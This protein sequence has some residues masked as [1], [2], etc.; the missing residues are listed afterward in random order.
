MQILAIYAVAAK[1]LQLYSAAENGILITMERMCTTVKN[2]FSFVGEFIDSQCQN[3]TVHTRVCG[4]WIDEETRRR[5][6]FI[7]EV[8]GDIPD[9]FFHGCPNLKQVNLLSET[10]KRI[11]KG[12]FAHCPS[13]T[14]LAWLREGLAEIDDGAFTGC[15]ALTFLQEED[16]HTHETPKSLLYIG[17]AAFRGTGLTDIEISANILGAYAFADCKTLETVGLY[18]ELS[19]GAFA[20]AGCTALEDVDVGC[21]VY[22]LPS[23]AFQDCTALAPGALPE[24]RTPDIDFPDPGPIAYEITTEAGRRVLRFPGS[25]ALTNGAFDFIL[26]RKEILEGLTRAMENPFHYRLRE[27]ELWLEVW[28]GICEVDMANYTCPP[29]SAFIRALDLYNAL[30]AWCAK[31]ETGK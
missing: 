30:Q 18:G 10:T 31:N 19:V 20:F 22:Y 23:T 14:T 8:D 26:Y 11:G 24:S 3:K 16:V 13:L 7:R 27:Q 28:N 1:Y 4:E 12:A 17:E 2:M 25:R 9:G 15:T 29:E 6:V 21:D 5:L